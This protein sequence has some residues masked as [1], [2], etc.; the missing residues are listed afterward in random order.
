MLGF[1][2]STVVFSVAVGLLNRHH[3]LHPDEQPHSL[4]TRILI[5][6]TIASI[7]IGWLVDK[8]DG[9]ANKPQASMAQIIHSG[10]PLLIAKAII[11]IN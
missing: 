4:K 2:I 7:G 8:L 3:G 1:C 6:A 9:D 5:I 11:G 10:D